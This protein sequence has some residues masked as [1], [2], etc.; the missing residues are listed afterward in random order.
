MTT[1]PTPTPKPT[2]EEFNSIISFLSISYPPLKFSY[3]NENGQ[4][5][6]E[7]FPEL[8]QVLRLKRTAQLD[9]V[10]FEK[11]VELL[12]DYLPNNAIT[13]VEIDISNPDMSISYEHFVQCAINSQPLPVIGYRKKLIYDVASNSLSFF[14]NDEKIS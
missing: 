6:N 11:T 3:A 10:L 2:F 8:M 1:T 4:T 5:L 7:T 14:I 12:S 9:A 13:S